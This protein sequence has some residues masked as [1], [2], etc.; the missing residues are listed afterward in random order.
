MK[1][2]LIVVLMFLFIG[3]TS[4]DQLY[5][6]TELSGK[7]K[8]DTIYLVL[9]YRAFAYVVEKNNPKENILA[10][11]PIQYS[12]LELYKERYIQYWTYKS[13]LK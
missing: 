11:Y 4:Y 10:L 1:T 13:F 3:C 5:T 12:K 9:D 8:G 6:K 2:F 7:V